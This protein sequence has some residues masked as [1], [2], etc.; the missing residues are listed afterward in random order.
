MKPA[1]NSKRPEKL[2]AIQEITALVAQSDYCFI[3]NYGSLTV[4]A[5]S[6][7]RRELAK[8]GSKAKVVKNAYLRRAAAEKG[9]IGLEAVLE[10]PTAMVTGAGDP[11]EVAKTIVAFLK[12]NDKAS[13]KGAQLEAATLSAAQVA[14]LSE[15]PSKD[16][17][18]GTLLGTML[19]PATSL[20]RVLAAPLT[21]VLYVLK[22]KEEK[23]GSAA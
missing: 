17:M 8:V 7:L 2:S 11:A 9:W 18:R 23:D 3:L 14:Q 10:G 13:V 22:A 12:K 6:E 21:G 20:V 4:S 19:A 1:A 16:V 15:L 5:F